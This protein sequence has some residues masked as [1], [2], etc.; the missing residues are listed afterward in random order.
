MSLYIN[1]KGE[2]TLQRQQNLRLSLPQVDSFHIAFTLL[3][4]VEPVK[5]LIIG[6]ICQSILV[7]TTTTRAFQTLKKLF[8]ITAGTDEPSGPYFFFQISKVR[9]TSTD[10][11]IAP[12][13]CFL[14]NFR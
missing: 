1:F 11:A 5:P 4:Y 13:P 12:S 10:G 9:L 8:G 14:A 7:L 2:Q 3:A 6:K